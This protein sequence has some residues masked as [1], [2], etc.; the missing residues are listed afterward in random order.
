M[1]Q[2]EDGL[3]YCKSDD[4]IKRLDETL[5]GMGRIFNLD[6]V[7]H[8]LNSADV[9]ERDRGGRCR[10]IFFETVFSFFPS[11]KCYTFWTTNQT[12]LDEYLDEIWTEAADKELETIGAYL[13]HGEGDPCDLFIVQEV[14]DES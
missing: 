8:E 7:E 1:N 9:V 5:D 10:C 6:E 13:E 2:K 4:D 3:K 14:D 11:G 12:E